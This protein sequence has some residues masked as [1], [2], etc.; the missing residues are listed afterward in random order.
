MNLG[1]D[2]GGITRSADQ[3]GDD[4]RISLLLMFYSRS[5]E[6]RTIVNSNSSD[7]DNSGVILVTAHKRFVL[8]TILDQRSTPLLVDDFCM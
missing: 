5:K 6:K 8:T 7:H 4:S 2:R 1:L 3:C